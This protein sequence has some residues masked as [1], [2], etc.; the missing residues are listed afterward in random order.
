MTL[1]EPLAR[2]SA[3]ASTLLPLAF[4]GWGAALPRRVVTNDDLAGV[5]D[6]SDDWIATRTGIRSRHVAGSGESTVDLAATA[7][8][9]ALDRAGVDAADVD[10]VVVATSTPDRALPATA[11][12]VA[13]RLGARGSACDVNAACAG[14]AYALHLAAAAVASGSLGTAVVVGAE[15][16]SS[17]VDPDDRSTAVLF[18]DGAGALVLRP[19]AAPGPVPPP[20]TSPGVAAH[21]PGVVASVLDGDPALAGHLEVPPGDAYLRMDGPEVFRAATRALVSSAREVLDRA[22]VAAS[23]VDAYVPHQ[24]NRRIIDAATERLGLDA[25]RVVITL[26]GH[27]N[28]SAA[29]I[30]LALAAAADD[31]RIAPGDLVLTSAMGAGMTWGSLL[32]RWG[33][34][35]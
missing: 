29:S 6:T 12:D 8:G 34:G 10:L 21:L 13:G 7:A 33:T 19:L 20:A 11:S 16:M 5:L 1:T 28:T 35:S 27:G 24:A 25:E 18:G 14:F 22:G 32:L 15:R 3:G 2:T 17:L 4:A 23:D 26:D 9:R 30:P 31:G